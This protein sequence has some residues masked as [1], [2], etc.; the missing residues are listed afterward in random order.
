MFSLESTGEKHVLVTGRRKG[1]SPSLFGTC[2]PHRGGQCVLEISTSLRFG[3][4]N[5]IIEQ[6]GF[7]ATS[8]IFLCWARFLRTFTVNLRV[9]TFLCI[10]SVH[11]SRQNCVVVKK[12]FP[13]RDGNPDCQVSLYPPKGSFFFFTGGGSAH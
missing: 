8:C 2:R 5:Q 7:V 12:F 3:T 6:Y 11:S 9:L 1:H 4:F 10:V 13:F